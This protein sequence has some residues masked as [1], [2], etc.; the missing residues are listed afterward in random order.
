MKKDFSYPV[1]INISKNASIDQ[2]KY[3]VMY[4]ESIEDPKKFW[5]EQGKKFISWITPW[6]AVHKNEFNNGKAEWF[7]GGK[8]NVSFNCVDRH[9]EERGNETAIVW[10]GDELNDSRNITYSELHKDICK[11]AIAVKTNGI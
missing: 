3:E 6:K 4:R 1:P 2:E 10:E 7:I 11:L 5:G 8:L 9:L